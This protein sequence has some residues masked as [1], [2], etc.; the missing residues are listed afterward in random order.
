[1][2]M[3]FKDKWNTRPTEATPSSAFA[4]KVVA[5]VGRNEDFAAYEGPSHWSDEQV[6]LEGSK[7]P[8][9]AAESLFFV[10][11]RLRWRD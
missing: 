11:R 8:Q 7:I 10:C 9:A 5:V 3:T 6:A 1:M 2:K 4:V